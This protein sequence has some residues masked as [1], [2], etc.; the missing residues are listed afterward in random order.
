MKKLLD[1]FGNISVD[2]S[3]KM[4]GP[5]N[6]GLIIFLKEN[7]TC[8]EPEFLEPV[9]SGLHVYLSVSGQVWL[10]SFIQVQVNLG[11]RSGQNRFQI[12][13]IRYL[14]CSEHYSLRSY[15]LYLGLVRISR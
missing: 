9:K 3:Q 8:S 1:L 15:P 2:R 13:Q 5:E 11:F 6:S 14:A 10:V 4:I 12:I 7:L